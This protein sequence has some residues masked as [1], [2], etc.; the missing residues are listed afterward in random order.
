MFFCEERMRT[1][2]GEGERIDVKKGR[3][4]GGRENGE[5]E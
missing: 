5:E 4:R 2:R 1:G 3:G